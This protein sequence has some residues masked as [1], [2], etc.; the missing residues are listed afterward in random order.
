MNVEVYIAQMG[1]RHDLLTKLTK[2]VFLD[3]EGFSFILNFKFQFILST[4]NFWPFVAIFKNFG[5]S[6]G[7]QF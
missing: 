7:L 6:G 1:L 5:A 2:L 4:L 3:S